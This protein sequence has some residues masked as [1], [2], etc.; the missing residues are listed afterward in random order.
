[1]DKPVD[2]DQLNRVKNKTVITCAKRNQQKLDVVPLFYD[3]YKAGKELLSNE[4]MFNGLKRAH[5]YSGIGQV[6][7]NLTKL[8]GKE[9]PDIFAAAC[10][11]R[12]NNAVISNI[13]TAHSNV[14]NKHGELAHARCRV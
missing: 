7:N 6:S 12:Y 1:M 14:R 8:W 13:V 4:A 11:C 3:A 2:G 9:D 10:L 5:E